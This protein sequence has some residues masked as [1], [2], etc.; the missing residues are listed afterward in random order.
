MTFTL[1]LDLLPGST[2]AEIQRQVELVASQ[3]PNDPNS[4]PDG[5]ERIEIRTG[6]PDFDVQGEWR[7][8]R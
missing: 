3:L 8:D 2:Y 7:I 5:P 4:K 1:R 6:D